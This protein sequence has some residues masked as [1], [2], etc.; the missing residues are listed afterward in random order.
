MNPKPSTRRRPLTLAR[1]FNGFL[2]IVVDVE[3]GGLE[4]QTD[5]L[6]ELAAFALQLTPNGQ[7][8]PMQQWHYHITPFPGARILPEALACNRIIPD[9]PFRYA[10]EEREALREWFT[11]INALLSST[12][13]RRAVLV[14]HNAAFDLNFVQAAAKRCGWRHP[15]LHPFISFDTTTLGALLLGETVLARL[16]Q[17]AGLSWDEREAHS[18]L[19]DAERTSALFCALYGRWHH[20][21]E[22]L[23]SRQHDLS[24]LPEPT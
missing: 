14:G 8:A 16:V 23:T 6:L 15:P 9:H 1:R 17:K 5:A 11:G 20:C 7:L 13:C 22:Q 24:S 21:Q 2:P 3:T 18:A 10:V 19:Y 12:G 4:A